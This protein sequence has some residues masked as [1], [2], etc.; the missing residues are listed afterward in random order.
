MR[1]VVLFCVFGELEVNSSLR[2]LAFGWFLLGFL[3]GEMVLISSLGSCLEGFVSI[4]FDVFSSLCS[5]I[6]LGFVLL[7]ESFK[8]IGFISCMNF[9]QS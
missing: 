9:G 2:F 8:S 4:Y 7:E 5:V 1:D 3:C 6:G